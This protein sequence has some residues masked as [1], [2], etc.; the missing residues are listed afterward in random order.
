MQELLLDHTHEGLVICDVSGRILYFNR[1]YENLFGL[2]RNKDIGRDIREIFPDARIPVVAQTGVADRGVIYKW[3][4]RKLVV[5]RIP[6]RHG[7]RIGGVITQVLFRDIHE[8]YDLHDRV[9]DLKNKIESIGAEFRRHF[10]SRYSLDDLI[11]DNEKMIK[12]KR[13]AAKYAQTNLPILILGESGTGKEILAHG[14]HHI[15]PRSRRAFLGINCA[16]MPAGLIEAEL[17]GHEAG[18]YTGA[19]QKGG[20]GKFELV[21]GG[22]LFIDEIGDMPYEMQAKILRVLEDG[23]I[24]RLGGTRKVKVDYRIVAAT[25]KDLE[26]MVEEGTFR[27]DLYYRLSTLVLRAPPLRERRDDLPLLARHLVDQSEPCLSA[28]KNV[29][30]SPEVLQTFLEYHWPGNIRELKN[31]VLS[32]LYRLEEGQNRIENQHLPAPLSPRPEAAPATVTPIRSARRLREQEAIQAALR[33][34]SGNKTAAAKILGISR[35][36]LYDKLRQ[37]QLNV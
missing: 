18:A 36:V 26:K 11:G 30:F 17:F 4:D 7:D 34:T 23:E 24:M 27:S 35:S 3:N 9:S 29:G 13:L 14:V 22:T 8:L 10:R 5:N 1:P 12:L 28:P 15:S 6:F 25:N 19:N 21:D 37:Y 16:A 2:D 20:I 31:V 33:A 32:A